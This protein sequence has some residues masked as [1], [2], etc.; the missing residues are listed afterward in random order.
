[1]P[2]VNDWHFTFLCQPA[3]C[4]S[5]DLWKPQHVLNVYLF[6]TW[7][8]FPRGGRGT[9][10]RVRGGWRMEDGRGGRP[11]ADP[12][13]AAGRHPTRLRMAAFS[14]SSQESS[15]GVKHLHLCLGVTSQLHAATTKDVGSWH[16]FPGSQRQTPHPQA[17]P[18]SAQC[19]DET[20]TMPAL[21][22]AAS[23]SSVPESSRPLVTNAELRRY[24]ER[25]WI[26]RSVGGAWESTF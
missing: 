23:D 18:M 8:C 20:W 13:R 24:T 14:A 16:I 25:F 9:R 7:K 1:M 2:D 6:E 15:A 5:A 3:C 4:I 11:C 26:C 12:Q 17:Q 10:L 19:E 21:R 22:A